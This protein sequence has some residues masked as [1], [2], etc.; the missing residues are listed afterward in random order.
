MKAFYERSFAALLGASPEVASELGV[1]DI[2]G[3]AVARDRFSDITPAGVAARHALI[4]DSLA[5]LEQLPPTADPAETLNRAIY[6]A[7]L[8]QGRLGRLRG[9]EG[10][11][12]VACEPAIDHLGSTQAEMITCLVE[13]QPLATR[14]DAGAYRARVAAMAA[15]VEAQ[16]AELRSRAATGNVVPAVIVERVCGEL[17]ELLA[18]PAA[19]H[20]V[21][22]RYRESAVG[23]A[24]ERVERQIERDVAP[25][26]ARLAAFLRNSYPRE[27]RIGLWRLPLGEACYGFLLRAHTTGALDPEASFAL[28]R[29]ELA[30]LQAGTLA[31]ARA[32][33]FPGDSL[34]DAFRAFDADPRFRP[35][36]SAAARARLVADLER[37]VG[38]AERELRPKFGLWPRSGVRIRPIE[39]LHEANRHSTYVPPAADG[40]RP[41]VFDLNVGQALS[42]NRLDA[43]T[44]AY[45]E[46]MPGHHVQLAL[47]QELDP[48][49]PAFRRIL[50]HDGYIEGW[51]KYAEVLPWLEGVNQ[52]PYWDLARS[53]S[54]LYSTANLMVDTGIHVKRWP[55]EQAVAFLMEQAGARRALAEAI[56]DRSIVWP[57]QLSSYKTGMITMLEARRRMERALGGRFDV[58]AFHDLVLRSGSMPLALLDQ[59]VDAQLRA[60]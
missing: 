57:G 14:E 60:R 38:E 7:F 44:L 13:W 1:H 53:R 55:R 12:L 31:K 16:I 2:G 52:D 51:A 15:Q 6:G 4:R 28:G 36:T 24:P 46:A 39:P 8:R 41:G 22:R 27:A 11:D 26:Y 19:D 9:T 50:V 40:S 17:D 47:A 45:H 23:A 20:P 21:A 29:D 48:A 18:L 43:Y 10:H 5:Q 25:A 30:R 37:I 58:R 56:V 54:E 49:L 59:A 33:G 32:L 42:G 3:H 34:P 35:D